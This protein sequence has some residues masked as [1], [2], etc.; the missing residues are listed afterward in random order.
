[1]NNRI[2]VIGGTA[3]GMSAAVKAKRLQPSLDIVVLE[4]SG[5]ISYGSCGLPYFI[6]GM[7]E[8]VEELL[9]LTP[10]TAA[11]RG[12]DVRVHHEAISINRITKMVTVKDIKSGKPYSIYYDSLVIAT[13]AVPVIPPIPNIYAAGVY[14]LRTIED[15]LALRSLLDQREVKRALIV[16]GG[17]IGLEMAE[18]LNLRGI[19]VSILEALPRILPS[20][21]EE[22]SSDIFETL[23]SK[24]V[25]VICDQS[26]SEI[27]VKEGR[28]IAA[29]SDKGLRF[30]V[31]LIIVSV[32]VRPNS[33]LAKA[34]GLKIGFKGGIVVDAGLRTSDD[35]IWACGD[36]VQMRHLLTDRE[37]YIPLGTTANKQGRITGGNI[38]GEKGSF[39]GVL[40]SQVAKVFDR[41]IASTGLNLNAAILAG[42]DAVSEKIVKSDRASYYPGG[43]NCSL[44]IIFDRING[45]LL[46]AQGI[47]GFSLAGRVNT[48]A[49]AI[50]SGLSIKQLNEIDFVYAPPVAPVYDPI[51]I[52]ASQGIKKIRQIE[53]EISP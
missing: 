20:F 28:V 19:D 18:Q 32:G 11:T 9:S 30:D 38:A 2:V 22:Y 14:T 24:G 23:E 46:G 40:G 52:V 8:S 48:L 35:S 50:S 3:A 51:L 6:G 10:E 39:T 34:S 17:F 12:I 1:M 26:L 29:L 21:E 41:Y 36:C 37:V 33:D 25:Q 4:R 44:C 49:V 31:D 47:G 42:F 53:L 27:E 43:S 45:R 15:G 16:G 7:I 13:G 5:F